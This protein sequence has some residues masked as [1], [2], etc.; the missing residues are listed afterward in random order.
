MIHSGHN[1]VDDR[2]V[3]VQRALLR[4]QALLDQLKV[5]GHCNVYKPPYNI[6]WLHEIQLRYVT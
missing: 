1:S 4:R 6:K 2:N 3:R 5:S